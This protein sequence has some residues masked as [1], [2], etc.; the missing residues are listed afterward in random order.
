[1]STRRLQTRFIHSSTNNQIGLTIYRLLRYSR[2]LSNLI[3]N[4]NSTRSRFV[5]TC[6]AGLVI[7]LGHLP[8]SLFV[9][10]LNFP[11]SK[12]PFSWS[13]VH[14]S[15]EW[16]YVALHRSYGSVGAESWSGIAGGL[17]IALTLG[18]GFE[19]RKMYKNFSKQMGLGRIFPSLLQDG[20]DTSSR[21]S[22]KWSL[23]GG[24]ARSVIGKFRWSSKSSSTTKSWQVPHRFS[25]SHVMSR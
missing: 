15:D 14:S 4:H 8:L 17:V 10:S 3:A 2:T 9:F 21:S 18:T 12:R 23:L 7:L 1:M 11:I 24:K 13:E 19:A 16:S 22:A 20:S 5:R 6:I 25:G